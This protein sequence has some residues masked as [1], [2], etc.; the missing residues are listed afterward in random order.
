MRSCSGSGG[1]AVGIDAVY[2]TREV[3]LSADDLSGL[4]RARRRVTLLGLGAVTLLHDPQPRGPPRMA[5]RPSARSCSAALYLAAPATIVPIG[6]G[7]RDHPYRARRRAGRRAGHA[8]RD[9]HVQDQGTASKLEGW[10]IP[11]R[12]GAAVIAFPGRKG[13]QRQARMLARHGYGVLLFDRRGEGRSEGE[14]NAF[15][16]G[17]DEDVKAASAT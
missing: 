8:A 6:S 5:L 17:G 14:P 7:L 2:Y 9:R 3:G 16:W 4:S 1:I 11:S 15:G 10:Y 12:N 13:P